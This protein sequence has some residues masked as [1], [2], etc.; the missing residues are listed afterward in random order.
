MK[1]LI[2]MGL[3]IC[4]GAMSL[5]GCAGGNKTA[6]TEAEKTEAA[7]ESGESAA[8]ETTEEQ[9]ESAGKPYF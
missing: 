8:A 3:A 4:M 6:P 9:S 5:T 7:S 1:K 2:A